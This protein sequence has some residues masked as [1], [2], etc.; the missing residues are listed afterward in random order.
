MHNIKEMDSQRRPG[1]P[2]SL[3][4]QPVQ[5]SCLQAI[6]AASNFSLSPV[7][8]QPEQAVSQTIYLKALTIP[9]YQPIQSERPQPNS[10]QPAGRS[11][12]NLKNSNMPLIL[13]PL[14]HS[15]GTDRL[16]A[17]PQKPPQTINIVSGL[18][19]LPQNSSPCAPLGSPG[20]SK[21]AGKH[22]CKHCGRDCLKPS[23]LEKHM[24]SHT[25]E[26]PFPCTTC[27]IA[28]KTQS[29][30]YK[31]RRTQTH[32]NNTRLPAESD[33][34]CLLEDNEKGAENVRSPQT[35]KTGDRNSDDQPRSIIK[36]AISESAAV[37]AGEK[38]PLS[39]S[40]P[41][42]T[43]LSLVSE[44]RGGTTDN[45]CHRGVNQNVLEK[46]AMKDLA[47][48][49][50]RRK[51]QEQRS[52]MVSQH[53]QLQRQQP[54]YP[55][56]LWDSKSPDY[57]LKKC[58]STDSGYLSRS[59]SVEQQMLSPSPLHSLCEH[60]TELEGDTA[61]SNLRSTAANHS[62]ADLAEK[63]AG[64][65][66]LEKKKLEEHISKLIS[67]N[68]EVVD[69]TQLDNVRPR[70]TVLSKQGSI[71]LPMPYTYKDSFHF[72]IRSLDVNKKKNISLC[73]AKSTFTP[74]EKVKP[75]FFHSVPTQ[76]STTIDFVPVTRSNSLPFVETTRRIQDRGDN[77]TLSAF[78][79]VP[80]NTSFSGLLHNNKLVASREDFPTSHPRALVR[81]SAVDD[82]PLGNVFESPPFP[83]DTKDAKKSGTRAEGGNTKCK[84]PTQRKVKMFSQEKWQ[85]YGDET[86]KKIYQKMKSSQSAKKQKG[87]KINENSSFQSDTKEVASH[88]KI[89]GHKSGRCPTPKNIVSSPVVVPAKL[90]T[91]ESLGSS[92]AG[93]ISQHT[94]Q[95][96]SGSV[97]ELMETSFSVSD[98]EHSGVPKTFSECRCRE[99]CAFKKDPDGSNQ[100]LSLS[101]SCELKLQLHQAIGQENNILSASLQKFANES[102]EMCGQGDSIKHVPEH[103]DI[104][105]IKGE[106]S[107]GKESI[108]STQGVSPLHQGSCGTPVEE[109]QKLPSERKKL[110][111]DELKS[112]ENTLK[113]SRGSNSSKDR[114]VKLLDQ[115]KI[116]NV[117]APVSINHSIKEKKQRFTADT[118]SLGSC[119]ECK[120]QT[121]QY[122]VMN[123]SNKD[124]IADNTASVSTFSFS[125]QL[126]AEVTKE[127]ICSSFSFH[128]L[129]ENPDLMITGTKL[130]SQKG[131]IATASLPVQPLV[132][133]QITPHIK[134]NEFLPKYI[135]KYPQ[136]GNS[137]DVPLVPLGELD[138]KACISL[139][140]TST[141]TVNPSSSCES[142]G[143]NLTDLCVC[144][145]QLELGHTTR[146]NELQWDAHTTWKSLVVCSPAIL[147]TT[148]ITTK[149]DR[150]HHHHQSACQR[151]KVKEILEEAEDMDNFGGAQE[152]ER[153]TVVCSSYASGKK[154]RFTSMYKG[155]FFI[156]SDVTGRNSALKLIRSGNSSVI[157]VSS[158][159]GRAAL[160]GNH[161]N[162]TKE[163]E[164][165]IN[166]LPRLPLSS[167][168][169]SRCLCHASDMLHCHVVCTPQKEVCTLSHL[170]MISPVG[171]SKSP[172][173]TVSF[174]TLNAEPR[175]TWC[176]L[177]RNLPLPV[178]QKEKKDSA[179]SSLHICKNEKV[180]LKC[181]LTFCKMKHTAS[182]GSTRGTSN[183]PMSS[184]N[185]RQQIEKP[186]FSTTGGDELLKNISEQEKANKKLCK[187]RELSTISKAKKSRKRKKMKINPKRYKGSYGHRHLL[188]KT[189]RLSRQLWS[190]SRAL[191]TPEKHRQLF[192]PDGP[193][194]CGKCLCLPTASQGHDQ[195]LQER[196][197]SCTTDEAASFV[198][199]YP[200]KEGKSDSGMTF[201]SLGSSC[202]FKQED[203]EDGQVSSRPINESLS[204]ILSLQTTATAPATY[205]CTLST[206]VLAQKDR[207][208]NVCSLGKLP[209]ERHPDIPPEHPCTSTGTCNFRDPGESHPRNHLCSEVTRPVFDGSKTDLK[210]VFCMESKSQ[211][212]AVLEPPFHILGRRVQTTKSN[213]STLHEKLPPV[214]QTPCYL[215]LRP[216]LL[217]ETSASNICL[218]SSR[219]AQETTRGADKSSS[220]LQSVGGQGKLCA[221]ESPASKNSSAPL[222]SSGTPS[223]SFKK[224]T[225]EMMNKQTHVEEDTSS[226]DEDRLIIEI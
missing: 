97:L 102:E 17:A 18:P 100:I 25:G 205:S 223:K 137:R 225:L 4:D 105:P 115:F 55:E 51:T 214:I 71:D 149:V 209:R 133:D 168:D 144:P 130:S 106:D 94:S 147:E 99:L 50:Q 135:L 202:N 92:T 128:K 145:L 69:D 63:T 109:S 112:K 151:E 217:T 88:E 35:T 103:E 163:R 116:I 53:T 2:V 19:V 138:Q 215:S 154:I 190:A 113:I 185:L 22:L 34:S 155:D 90:N 77:S 119:V 120:Q 43:A 111:V 201:L 143:T 76:F 175:L 56:R 85:V 5:L 80:P 87:N 7:I 220:C 30:L 207:G 61:I 197:P 224:Q 158:L 211:K 93:Q 136:E 186:Y 74:I 14:V 139:P 32:V 39:T 142:L 40:L 212:V 95:E 171:N 160:C 117:V 134:K 118:N 182:E 108:P 23:V 66:A 123:S 29:N 221:A 58:E 91:E 152:G 196:V 26:R 46:E 20:K 15:E 59:D 173:L 41:T 210:D 179:Y 27:G 153:D 146:T 213:F 3:A 8:L 169:N 98:S 222:G 75:L 132:F 170:S 184:F 42:V 70:K 208:L 226:E 180:S 165:D 150:R 122:P 121:V 161:D 157:S 96:S 131:G 124:Y 72:D 44:I 191:E 125:E 129:S 45:S 195:N 174:P 218:L 206:H 28:F 141:D 36:Q 86:F 162:E 81:Q 54:T 159:V 33:G 49:L 83:E 73:S 24:R 200:T 62:K 183:T 10:Q 21:S 216:K 107:G 9:L 198:K 79:R 65:L 47:N 127:Y 1:P 82:L 164:V 37:V 156:S 204:S 166:S 104:S 84:K 31:H 12:F 57:K 48:F 89:T 176:C 140:T 114:I 101:T 78:T 148:S 52:P 172:S 194:H 60:S 187:I 64:S 68:K 178:E 177:T 193:E 188:L 192:A 203:S 189:S 199:K 13:S 181:S 38:L 11:T 67:H 219:H 6:P 167:V 110:K 16:Q 126:R